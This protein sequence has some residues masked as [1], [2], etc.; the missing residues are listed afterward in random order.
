[1][2]I[3]KYIFILF[4]IVLLALFAY[5]FYNS[6]SLKKVSVSKGAVPYKFT[7]KYYGNIS[8]SAQAKHMPLL[9]KSLSTKVQIT[10]RRNNKIT[11]YGDGESF[12]TT[13][14]SNGGFNGKLRIKE[15]KCSGLLKVSGFVNGKTAKGKL[16]GNGSCEGIAITLNG[17]FSANK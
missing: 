3:L 4:V 6:K 1:M 13:I 5:D 11:F 2:K 14:G 8:G 7:G 10:V 15:K 17:K 12:T 16:G 9:R